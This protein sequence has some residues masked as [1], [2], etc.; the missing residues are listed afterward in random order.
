MDG[1]IIYHIYRGSDGMEHGLIVSLT[2]TTATWQSV[3]SL[4]N[5]NRSWDGLYNTDLMTNSPAKDFVTGLGAG[6]YLPSV[7]ELSILYHNRFYVNKVLFSG[8]NTLLSNFA[9]Y[10]SSTEHNAGVAWPFDFMLGLVSGNN[11]KLNVH[12]VRGVKAF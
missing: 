9:D 1:G 4:V 12:R 5:A 7:D 11:A 2:E 6:W 10:W 8:G 3:T